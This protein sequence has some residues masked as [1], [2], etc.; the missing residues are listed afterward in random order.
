VRAKAARRDEV[1]TQLVQTLSGA[2]TYT[3]ATTVSQIK[4]AP[5]FAQAFC[6]HSGQVNF[7]LLDFFAL[8]T[9]GRDCQ[10]S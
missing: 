3:G 2:N 1:G 4:R 8:P 5:G 6:P 7:L 9:A 10:W